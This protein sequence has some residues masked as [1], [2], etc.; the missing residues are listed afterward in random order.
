MTRHVLLISGF[1]PTHKNDRYVRGTLFDPAGAEQ[2]ERT[3]F[4]GRGSF[5]LRELGFDYRGSRYPL[6]RSRRWAVPHLTTFT[7]ESILQRSG[8][9]YSIIDTAAIWDGTARPPA[10][11]VDLVLLSTTFIWDRSTL[12]GAVGWVTRELPG[13]PIVLGGQYSNLKWASVLRDHREI[14]AVVRGDA[15]K[16]LPLLLSAA[17]LRRLRAAVP[18]LIYRDEDGTVQNNGIE[19]VDF[20]SEPAP[21]F[22]GAYPSVPYES[23]RGCPFSCKFCSFPAASPQWRYRSA[24]RIR[25]DWVTYAERNGATFVKAMDSTFTVP[26]TRMRELFD[27]LPPTGMAWEA[28]SRANVIRDQSVVERLTAAHCRTLS[29][30]FES[31]SESSLRNMNKKVTA[32]ANL[33]AFQLLRNSPVGYRCSFMVGYPGET[34]EDYQLTH[35]FLV[36]EFAGHFTLSVFGVSD[37]TMPLWQDRERFAI[38][39]L[40]EAN[41]DFSWRHVGM[42]VETAYALNHR[43]LD[44]VR[45]RNDDAVLIIWQDTYQR[46]LMPALS[47]ADN[48]RVEKTVERIAMLPRDY[49]DPRDG[50]PV[51]DGLLDRLARWG[52]RRGDPSSYSHEP[53]ITD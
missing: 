20:D 3:Y 35:D 15:E 25:D 11:D 33:T 9:D 52:C 32:K 7:L 44:E 42:D 49:P 5:S 22:A 14:A 13:C 37:E 39:V 18:N 21:R 19:Y 2:V 48:L 51:L 29:I 8:F 30:G 31:M 16:A 46:W 45:R 6:M 34:P 40:D 38:E 26:P 36:Q 28:Y 4:G 41:P 53:L 50:L 47:R 1:G 24:K 10:R 43:T 17:D 23:M 12:A 27:L